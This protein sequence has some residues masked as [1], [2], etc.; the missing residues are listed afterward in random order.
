MLMRFGKIIDAEEEAA[1]DAAEEEAAY[2]AYLNDY[3]A[4]VGAY[5]RYPYP[6]TAANGYYGWP[7]IETNFNNHQRCRVQNIAPSEALRQE[8]Q[9]KATWDWVID[10][11]TKEEFEGLGDGDS[12][13]GHVEGAVLAENLGSDDAA[14]LK[15]LQHLPCKTARI[16]LVCRT[17]WCFCCRCSCCCF[18]FCFC[19][20]CRSCYCCC[21]SCRFCPYA[22][23]CVWVCVFRCLWSGTGA[24]PGEGMQRI[25]FP[26]QCCSPL[27]ILVHVA[28]P[29]SLL[30][31]WQ[32]FAPLFSQIFLVTSF[33]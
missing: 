15:A 8:L 16:L 30:S 10:V 5:A 25:H 14:L 4:R 3:Y 28:A 13:L 22:Y 17:G 1:Y 32:L 20:C 23:C 33:S 12:G 2:N 18:C 31:K 26:T 9:D 6:Y 7:D 21:P 27:D 11:R 24:V 29:L 19:F